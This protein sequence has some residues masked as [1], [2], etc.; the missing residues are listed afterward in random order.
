[1]TLLLGKTFTFKAIVITLA[2][3]KLG[4]FGNQFMISH[5]ASRLFISTER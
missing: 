2:F 4:K 5:K 1:M 3:Y